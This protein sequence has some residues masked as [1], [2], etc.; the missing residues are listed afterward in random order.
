MDI[1]VV[2]DA[3]VDV[4]RLGVS[5][6]IFECQD[7]RLFH[8]IA[9][10]TCQRELVAFALRERGLDKQDFSAHTCPGQTGHHTGIFVALI[11]IAVER[12]F[13]QQVLDLRRR[14]LLIIG[15]LLH[16]AFVGYLAE[17]LVNLLLQLSHT[18]LTGI[19]LDDHLDGGL[20]KRGFHALHVL[21]RILQFARYQVALG[22]LD[23]LLGDIAAHLDHFH[24]VE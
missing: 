10:I 6:H 19:A 2:E 7:G 8:H 13:A 16:L 3:I 20:V 24:T 11:D 9:Q 23:L 14:D 21:T 1:P 17:G 4:Q 5:L 15:I 18:T 22:Y 12:R